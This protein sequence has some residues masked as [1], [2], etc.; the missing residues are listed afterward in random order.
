MMVGETLCTCSALRRSE[1]DFA[2]GCLGVLF[3]FYV[4]TKVGQG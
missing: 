4:S 2:I 1:M 3:I